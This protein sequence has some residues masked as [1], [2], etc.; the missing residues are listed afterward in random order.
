M[1]TDA[2]HQNPDTDAYVLMRPV[3]LAQLDGPETF[4][5]IVEDVLF[6]VDNWREL[7][8]GMQAAEAQKE[9]QT[10]TER[11]SRVVRQYWKRACNL[12]R[13]CVYTG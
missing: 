12:L 11:Q 9:K 10:D 8:N 7:M 13:S 3:P 4:G 1:G 2:E 6:Q 5:A